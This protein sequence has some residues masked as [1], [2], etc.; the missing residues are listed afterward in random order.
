MQFNFYNLVP[1]TFSLDWEKA[2]GTRL[3]FLWFDLPFTLIRQENEAF[4]KRSC[5]W[6]NL[7]TTASSFTVDGKC[8]GNR[9]F[10]KRWRHY[11]HVISLP[12]FSSNTTPKPTID[13][14]VFK[15]LRRSV[16]GK[17]LMRFPSV[18]A[19]FKFVWRRWVHA[20]GLSLMIKL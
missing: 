10:R 12:E 20:R 7:E 17:R 8:F 13:C 3:Q 18:K 4:R 15:I 14:Y 19:V 5:N 6:G 11:N 16:E 1:R 9:G 2:L